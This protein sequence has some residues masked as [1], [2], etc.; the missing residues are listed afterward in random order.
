[1]AV[2]PQRRTTAR[3]TDQGANG[4]SASRASRILRSASESFGELCWTYEEL[5]ERDTQFFG[6][7][8]HQIGLQLATGQ[9]QGFAFR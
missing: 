4:S 1:M 2:T 5:N 8:N 7:R 9:G 6:G 3:V